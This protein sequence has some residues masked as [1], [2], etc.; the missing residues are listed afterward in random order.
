MTLFWPE[1]ESLTVI[2]GDMVLFSFFLPGSGLLS[3][4]PHHQCL[5]APGSVNRSLLFLQWFCPTELPGAV[6]TYLNSSTEGLYFESLGCLRMTFKMIRTVIKKKQ[7]E[8]KPSKHLKPEVLCPSLHLHVVIWTLLCA[9]AQQSGNFGCSMG[10]VSLT[11]AVRI[12]RAS[13]HLL[14]FKDHRLY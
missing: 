13:S 3:G 11:P 6:S 1:Y 5:W 9:V 12:L 4:G 8:K 10:S 7:M 14:L 2:F